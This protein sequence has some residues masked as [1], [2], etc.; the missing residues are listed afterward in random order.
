[1][2]CDSVVEDPRGLPYCQSGDVALSVLVSSC[3]RFL[4]LLVAQITADCQYDYVAS[5]EYLYV[6]FRRSKATYVLCDSHFSGT[7]TVFVYNTQE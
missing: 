3:P 4:K 2:F 5:N 6:E 7:T 1:M